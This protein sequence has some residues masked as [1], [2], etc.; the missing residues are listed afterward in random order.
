MTGSSLSL[1]LARSGTSLALPLRQS[2]EWLQKQGFG[3]YVGLEFRPT[4]STNEAL[5]ET[6]SILA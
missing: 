3:G 6:R 1:Q 5:A 2:L 4:G